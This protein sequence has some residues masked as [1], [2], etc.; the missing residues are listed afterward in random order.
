MIPKFADL[1]DPRVTDPVLQRP[2]VFTNGVFDLLHAG[3]VTYLRQARALGNSLFVAINSD[4]S[5]RRLNKGPNR[6]I[7]NDQDRATVIAALESVSAVTIFDED[8]PRSALIQIR[9]D[10]YVKGGDY[11]MDALEETKMV[12][13]W[14]GQALSIP[15]V[16]G[17]STTSIIERTQINIHR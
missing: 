15:F 5:A 7:N 10:I 12:R 4:N 16:G 6:P 17:Y 13:S 8:K 14:N 9:P 1:M 2:V 3:H 11:D